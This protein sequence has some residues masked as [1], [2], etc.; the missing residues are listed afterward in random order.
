MSKNSFRYF[1]MSPAIMQLAVL[2]QALS[3][4]PIRIVSPGPVALISGEQCFGS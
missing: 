1:K 3:K 2:M 4:E